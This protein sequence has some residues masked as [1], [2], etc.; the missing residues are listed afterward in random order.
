MPKKV[1]V[2]QKAKKPRLRSPVCK[3]CWELKYCPY[4]PLVENFPLYP[5][6]NSLAEVKQ[7]FANIRSAIVSGECDSDADLLSAIERLH[8]H[9]PPRYAWIKKFE[10]KELGCSVFGHICPVFFCAE[11]FTETH[12]GRRTGRHIPRDIM[13]KVVRRDGQ[14]CQLCHQPVRD[15][16]VEFDHLIPVARGGPVSVENLRL[17]CRAC[18]R[19]K[20]DSLAEVVATKGPFER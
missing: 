13:L 4:G 7:R 18:N 16:E 8:V 11:P 5:E 3:P 1:P 6:D 14:I 15:N 17:L 9:Y 12:E 10:T 2:K 20:C 19:H